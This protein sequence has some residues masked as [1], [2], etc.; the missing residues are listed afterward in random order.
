M[1]P[2]LFLFSMTTALTLG[3][4]ATDAVAQDRPLDTGPAKETAQAP[5]LPIGTVARY[6][7]TYA[8][9][10]TSVTALRSVSIVSITNQSPVTCTV[11]VDWRIGFGGV[12]CGT[13][14]SLPA[15]F[16]ADFCTR[17]IPGSLTTCNSTCPA[18]PSFEGNAFVGSSTTA[19][20]EKIAVSARTVYTATTSDSPVSAITDAKVVKFGLGNIGD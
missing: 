19:G 1:K 6:R 14:F 4:G 11:A 16:T 2:S 8:I 13:S 20:C 7:V 18:P 3:M 17:P 5:A 15:G 12:V 9:S 10:S